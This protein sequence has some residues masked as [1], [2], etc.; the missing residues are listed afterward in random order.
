MTLARKLL[1]VAAALVAVGALVS[2][3]SYRRLEAFC[4]E[5]HV[6][7]RVDVFLGR[8]HEAG[9]RLAGADAYALHNAAT[10]P[11][12]AGLT[13]LLALVVHPL[14]PGGCTVMRDGNRIEQVVFHRGW[15]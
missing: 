10:L 6:A 15:E 8:V 13:L 9:L 12:P 2:W 1:L 7:S 11:A 3:S 4:A 5:P 14:A